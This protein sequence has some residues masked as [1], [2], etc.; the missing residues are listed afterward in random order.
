MENRD[1]L[2]AAIASVLDAMRRGD[3]DETRD[4]VTSLIESGELTARAAVWELATADASILRSSA[5]EAEKGIQVALE[6]CDPNGS[7]VE[8]DETE[9]SLRAAVRMLLALVNG[10]PGDALAQQDLVTEQEPAEM[11]LVFLH[12]A[13]WMLALLGLLDSVEHADAVVPGWLR[14]LSVG[15]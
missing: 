11:A 12:L 7:A 3:E 14:H 13:G 9:P 10:C 5:D 15:D 1:Y 8:I 4:R 2:R 6:L